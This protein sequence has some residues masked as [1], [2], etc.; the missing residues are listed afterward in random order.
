MRVVSGKVNFTNLSR[1][2]EL[3]EKT[4]RQQFTEEVDFG[5][6][7]GE[8]I[9][10]ANPSSH[11]QLA[12]MDCSFIGKSGKATFGLDRFWNGCHSRVE[13]GLEGSLVGVVEVETEVGY[14]LHAQQTFAPSEMEGV[15]RMGQYLGH[16][17][18]VRPYL[19]SQVQSLAVDGAYAKERFV[20][21]AVR[22]QWDVISNLRWDANLR[23]LYTGAQKKRGR[24]RKCNPKLT[25]K[26]SPASPLWN[27][28]NPKL[29]STAPESGTS[30]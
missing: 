4:Y 16:L 17:T 2:R 11:E 23:S 1:Y 5:R 13:R 10:A 19:P 25:S 26:T 29:T 7:N 8:L 12:G 28:C 21:G 30:P 27:P 6:L 9:K 14:A 18:E 15:S 3:Y 22:L 20:T 24:P